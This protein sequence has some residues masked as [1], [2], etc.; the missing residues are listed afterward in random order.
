M[1]FESV[2]RDKKNQQVGLMR[3]FDTLQTDAYVGDRVSLFRM[4]LTPFA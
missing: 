2:F 1:N 3:P 4:L